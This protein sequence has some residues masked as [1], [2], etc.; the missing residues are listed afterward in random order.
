[1]RSRAVQVKQDKK[2]WHGDSVNAT[3]ARK[4]KKRSKEAHYAKDR[5][6][7]EEM[8]ENLPLSA[9]CAIETVK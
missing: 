9:F 1:M 8:E 2:N 4:E 6:I 3:V 5:L 7:L